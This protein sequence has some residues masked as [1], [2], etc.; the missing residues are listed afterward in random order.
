V[1]RVMGPLDRDPGRL[2]TFQE[3]AKPEYQPL[4]ACRPDHL[5]HGSVR[6]LGVDPHD[7]LA[8]QKSVA[9]ELRAREAAD[10][11]DAVATALHERWQ[12]VDDETRQ[13]R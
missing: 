5:A 8:Q 13:L 9:D 12:V 6:L 2:L 3:D 10:V 11:A 1:R 4:D 7:D